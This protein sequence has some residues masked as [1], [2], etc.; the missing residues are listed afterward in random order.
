MDLIVCELERYDVVV[1]ALQ[2]TKWFGSKVYEV[3]GS[4]QLTSG[5]VTPAPG[6]AVRRGE[7]VALA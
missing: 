7:G 2:E 4:V 6:D 5:R 3:S 1:G